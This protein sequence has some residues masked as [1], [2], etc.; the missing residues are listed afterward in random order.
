MSDH[1]ELEHLRYLRGGLDALRED[2]RDVKHRLTT[3]DIEA[4]HLASTNPA[5]MPAWRSA[6]IEPMIGWIVPSGAWRSSP[7]TELHP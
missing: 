5:I 4:T 2:V 6:W 3:L 7:P 1:L